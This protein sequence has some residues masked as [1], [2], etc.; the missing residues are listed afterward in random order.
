MLYPH[1]ADKSICLPLF[2]KVLLISITLDTM[3]KA[4]TTF[5]AMDGPMAT[6]VLTSGDTPTKTGVMT[7]AVV[8]IGKATPA[9]GKARGLPMK[10]PLYTPHPGDTEGLLGK[11]VFLFRSR[12]K[13]VNM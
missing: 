6:T 2:Q 13:Y 3:A 5:K 12:C 8:E 10:N 9:I 7:A 1:N 11:Y 4:Q